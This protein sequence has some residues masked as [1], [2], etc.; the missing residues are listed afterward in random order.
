MIEIKCKFLF[1]KLFIFFSAFVCILVIFKMCIP[2]NV[3]LFKCL[4]GSYGQTAVVLNTNEIF[5]PSEADGNSVIS[6]KLIPAQVY[7]IKLKKFRSLNV[8]MN[9]PRTSYLAVLLNDGRILIWGGTRC[10]TKEPGVEQNAEIYNPKSN[11][12]ELIGKT[13][14]KHETLVNSNFVKLKDGRIFMITAG[15]A[16]I[17]DPKTNKFY[18]AGKTK[19]Y[20]QKTID[21]K[22]AKK[23]YIRTTNN[24][25]NRRNSLALLTDGRV[26]VIGTNIDNNPN[27]AEIYNPRTNEFENTG[28][29]NFPLFYRDATT[30]QDGRV[31]VT[32]GTQSYYKESVDPKNNSLI[33]YHGDAEIFDPNNNLFV[34]VGYLN[35]SRAG[36]RSILLSNGKVLIVNGANGLFLDK[37]DAKQAELYDPETNKFELIGRTKFGRMAFSVEPIDGKSIFINSYNGWEIYNY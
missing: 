11:K 1:I 35:V 24:I 23:E 31:L 25:Y 3:S 6:Q 37:K 14:F 15:Q 10:R 29:Q 5:L 32:G 12:F 17:F 22:E 19:K 36:H 20:H 34:P 4:N 18:I 7:D 27:N 30:L 28:N 21:D 26:L 33:L 8:Y 2:Q 16:E 9:I 13:I